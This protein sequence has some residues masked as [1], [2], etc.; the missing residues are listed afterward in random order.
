MILLQ[1]RCT[2]ILATAMAL[3]FYLPMK[4]QDAANAQTQ[5]SNPASN[6]K[7]TPTA[8]EDNL[9]HVDVTPYLWFPG[10]HGTAGALGH[11]A[12]VHA[13]AGDMLSHFRF[14]LMGGAEA[15]HNRFLLNGDL[16]WLRLRDARALP[17]TDPVAFS[18][19]VKVSEVIWT[20]KVGYRV[21]DHEKFKADANVGLRYWHL[22]QKLTLNPSP[23]GNSFNGSQN[24]VDILLGGRVQAPLSK[25]TAIEGG[26]D[27]GGWGA[28]AKLD[29][30]FAGVLS[31][32]I[33][34][35]WKLAAGYRY[36]L[37][38]YRRGSGIY[39]LVT[40]GPILGA[41]YTLK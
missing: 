30:Q 13:S 14:G 19:E 15:R 38:D 12:S 22:G 26:G 7:P 27:V 18:A 10:L 31:H 3:F 16:M 36:M 11:N 8:T 2:F 41:T 28:A 25:S 23:L 20:S 17:I 5:V 4:A 32:K 1:R 9:W 35:R 34:S 29:Y 37:I 39:N 6:S 40:A 21:L 24:W 33:S